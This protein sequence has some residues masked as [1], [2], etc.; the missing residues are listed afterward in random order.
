MSNERC[1]ACGTMWEIVSEHSGAGPTMPNVHS[2]Q[3]FLPDCKG[4]LSVSP[5]EPV[6]YR[7][8]GASEWRRVSQH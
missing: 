3:C 4:R 2:V 5:T 1:E 8:L 7:E 6:M